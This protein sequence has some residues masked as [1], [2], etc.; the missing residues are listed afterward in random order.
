MRGGPTARSAASSMGIGMDQPAWRLPRQQAAGEI[1]DPVATA[2]RAP[3]PSDVC[4]NQ[5]Q[6]R[7]SGNLARAER[8]EVRGV[9]LTVDDA[10]RPPLEL[11]D[12]MD[13][14]ELRGVGHAREHRLA[15]ERAADRNAVQA[16]DKIAVNPGLDRVRVAGVVEGAVGLDHLIGDPRAGL[17][18]PRRGAR[19][20]HVGETRCRRGP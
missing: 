15:E 10:E 18:R 20:H 5:V 17:A 13:E 6:E 11:R 12:E 19:L 3:R 7:G 9:H 16:A 8:G 14:R 4:A 1:A 2:T